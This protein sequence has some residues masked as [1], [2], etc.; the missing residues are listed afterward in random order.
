MSNIRMP[1]ADLT[2]V[3]N[4]VRTHRAV[5]IH[6]LAG[7]ILAINQSCLNMC[8]Y[9]RSQL[10]GRPVQMLLDPAEKAPQR[11]GTMLDAGRGKELH[12]RGLR[13]VSRSGRRYRV[14]A[15]LRPVRNDQGE[16][17]LNAMFM[18][19]WANGNITVAGGGAWVT[20]IAAESA[21]VTFPQ[22]E[23][24]ARDLPQA[25]TCAAGYGRTLRR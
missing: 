11:I 3:M 21:G 10:I 2:G 14:D 18:N 8:G 25:W 17:C 6:D 13:Q 4:T 24:D 16:I 22:N 15:Y 23:D 5:L 19:E 9:Q 1:D 12:I 7:H 20:M